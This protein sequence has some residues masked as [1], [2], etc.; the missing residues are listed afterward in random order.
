[1]TI[2]FNPIP[3]G[4]G[5]YVGGF[6]HPLYS[7]MP[8][9]DPPGGDEG[10][11]GADESGNAENNG[12]TNEYDV[13]D[14][15][16]APEE[17]PD[18][19][20]ATPPAVATPPAAVDPLEQLDAHFAKMEFGE[21][22][23]EALQAATQGDPIAMNEAIGGMLRGVMAKSAVFMAQ[24][25][26][27][28]R[29]ELEAKMA[30]TMSTKIRSNEATAALHAALPFAAN[31]GVAPVVTP[32]FA[33]AL[34]RNK[35]NVT[36]SITEVRNFLAATNKLSAKDLGQRITPTPAPGSEDYNELGDAGDS[37]G[38]VDWMNGVFKALA[39]QK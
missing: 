33:Q 39:P 26:Q 7:S 20:P 31:P 27:A 22:P 6:N 11:G 18:G 35:G 30:S 23:P 38:D 2:R 3:V 16:N 28:Q 21:I 24:A 5:P 34:R 8:N 14:Y 32:I 13:A 25:M 10:G 29:T 9:E 1:M 12:G 17:T 36:A 19:G 15:W 37:A 4:F